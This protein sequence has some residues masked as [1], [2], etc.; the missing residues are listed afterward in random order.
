MTR[1]PRLISYLTL[2]HS[3]IYVSDPSISVPGKITGNIDQG[4][5]LSADNQTAGLHNEHPQCI[6]Q[7]L[8]T[9]P[10]WWDANFT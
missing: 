4:N 10:T 9:E 3:T 6:S 8:P 1:N 7:P 2:G 5:L